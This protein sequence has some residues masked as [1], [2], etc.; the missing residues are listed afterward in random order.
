MIEEVTTAIHVSA[1]FD[2]VV[3]ASGSFVLYSKGREDLAAGTF[4]EN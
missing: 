4:G 2:C 1:G 3:D